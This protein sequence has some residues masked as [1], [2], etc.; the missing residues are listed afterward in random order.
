CS[1]HMA[2]QLSKAL[3]TSD[4]LGLARYDCIQPRYN[5][6]FREIENELLPLC[7]EEGVGVIPYN[8]LAGGMLT[9]KHSRDSGPEEGGRF[10]LG[11]AGAL[12]RKRYWRDA[13]FDAVDHMQAF[14][15]ERG[16]PL[17]AVAVAW[18]LAQQVITSA[19]VGASKPEHL[20]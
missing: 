20:D 8:P 16:K 18:V 1:N 19:I 13:T 12:Y 6:L 4:K 3:W 7:R 2:Y 17:T 5:V 9:G 11:N 10:T 15:E 14:F